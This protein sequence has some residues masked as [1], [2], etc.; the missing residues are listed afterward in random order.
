M[1]SMLICSRFLAS[2]CVLCL[3]AATVPATAAAKDDWAFDHA[4]EQ[5]RQGEWSEACGLFIELANNG[6]RDAA[7]IALFMVRYGPRL[8][9]SHWDASPDDVEEWETLVNQSPKTLRATPVFKPK[10]R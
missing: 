10:Y 8:Y 6:D 2:L 1:T 5:Y 7:R 9:G 4:V 3:L